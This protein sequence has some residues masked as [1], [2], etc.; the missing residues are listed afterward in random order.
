MS[1]E[2]YAMCDKVHDD[3]NHF[4]YSTDQETHGRS[5]YWE[6]IG[7][8]GT[9]DC[10]DFVLE[11]R[12]RLLDAGVPLQDL[13]IGQVFMPNGAAHAVLVIRDGD[14]DWVA[15]QTQPKLMTADEMK[16]LGYQ[17]RALQVPGETMWE[18][19]KL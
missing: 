1:S 7:L 18:E 19:W 17:A 8:A 16:R 14:V 15:D 12:Q 2:R 11:K 4:P 13:R 9:G 3:V 5:D 6:R 10:E